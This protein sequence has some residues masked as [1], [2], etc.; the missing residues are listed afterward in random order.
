MQMRDYISEKRTMLMA[1][2]RSTVWLEF[3][4]HPE[5]LDETTK[6]SFWMRLLKDH[7]ILSP[8]LAR[9][10]YLDLVY[11]S[12][13]STLI[14]R[15]SKMDKPYCCEVSHGVLPDARYVGIMLLH[16]HKGVVGS[17]SS[18]YDYSSLQYDSVCYGCKGPRGEGTTIRCFTGFR[19][20]IYLII[21]LSGID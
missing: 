4:N 10:S 18:P 15:V 7:G 8:D 9:V 12:A 17:D 19:Y 16:C 21:R 6:E 11:E 2:I 1:A 14:A 3:A 20:V 5:Q 13:S